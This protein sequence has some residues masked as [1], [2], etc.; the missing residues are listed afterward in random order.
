VIGSPHV[1]LI[2]TYELGHQPFG[3]AS[4]AAWLAEAGASVRCLDLA[5]EP[6]DEA[7]V[8]AADLIAVYVPMHTATRLAAA[9][10]PRLKALNPLAHLCAYGLYAPMNE[11]YLRALGA[12]AI[13]GGEFE[14]GL[15]ELVHRLRRPTS[16]AADGP[17]ATVSLGRQRFLPP[18]REGLPV[19]QRYAYLTLH[20]GER[21]VVGYTEASRGCLHLC[22]HCPIPPV[23]GGVL[24]IVQPE[25]VLDDIAAQVAAGAQHITFGDP[26]F[27][28]GP[29]H[30]RRIVRSLH[31]RFPDLTYD[32]TIKVEHLLEHAADLPLLRATGCL[33]VTSAVEAVDDAILAIFA[34][35]HT[36]RDFGLAV[37][38]LREA[39][40]ALNP[41]F[42]AFTPWT[43]I[44]GYHDFLAVL[45]ALDLVEN[46]SP[47]QYAIRL[48]IPAGS[49][50]LELDGVRSLVGPYDQAALAYP[51]AHSDPRVDHLQR[52]VGR[53]VQ[54]GQRGGEGRRAIYQ[55]VLTLTEQELDGPQ[56]GVVAPLA[57]CIGRPVPLPYLSEPWYC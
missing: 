7:G 49:L 57:A 17:P 5:V 22:R 56:N 43:T 54:E 39:G 19:L 46:V 52:A 31:E 16:G 29:G 34:K 53:A 33:L 12:G 21:R 10:L 9:L 55:R 18:Q 44:G 50:L 47:I 35:G 15:V 23:Y 36:S 42:V 2:S 41:T 4:P 45:D 30:A 40:L 32:V 1:L 24:R 28:N 26:D 25:V 14:E 20:T 13:L 38:L 3:L 51:W 37:R 48:L 6:L 27:F 11:G 8:V